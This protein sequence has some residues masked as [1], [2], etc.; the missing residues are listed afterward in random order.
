MY[1][2]RIKENFTLSFFPFWQKTKMLYAL[3]FAPWGNMT[4]LK[5]FLLKLNDK[6]GLV[7]EREK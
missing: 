5:I 1:S 6:S 7:A 4:I 2:S 3:P